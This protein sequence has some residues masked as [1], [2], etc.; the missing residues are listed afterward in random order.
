MNM[1]NQLILEGNILHVPETKQTAN[2]VITSFTIASER[3]YKT[4]DGKTATEVGIYD[5]ECYGEAYVPYLKK[6]E[7]GRG[8]RVVGRLKQEHWKDTDGNEHAKIYIVAEHIEIKP[9][10]PKKEAEYV[11]CF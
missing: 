8:I 6:L 3:T 10:F 7:K 2:K 1:L 9:H 11:V 4:F 5:C